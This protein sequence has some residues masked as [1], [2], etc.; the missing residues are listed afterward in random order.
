VLFIGWIAL[1]FQR[2][3]FA[4]D[5]QYRHVVCYESGGFSHTLNL[6]FYELKDGKWSYYQASLQGVTD[7][8]QMD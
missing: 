6:C 1:P 8:T 4:A 7:F 2:L 5:L 3:V